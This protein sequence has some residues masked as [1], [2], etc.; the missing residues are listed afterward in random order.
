MKTNNITS[1]PHIG[2]L[3]KTFFRARRTRK[4]VLARLMQCN[5]SVL[6]KIQKK[7]SLQISLLWVLCHH[8]QNNFFADLAAQLPV[9]FTSNAPI[10]TTKDEII[11]KLSEEINVL[12]GK[13]EL[14]ERIVNKNT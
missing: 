14:L 4:A 6:S 7:E 5:P 8:L 9:E 1:S 2:N 3:L 13:L 10:D 12:K 11:T